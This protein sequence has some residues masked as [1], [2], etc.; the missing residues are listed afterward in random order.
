MPG[1]LPLEPRKAPRQ[2]RAKATHDALV[3]A[4]AQVL[5]R[6]GLAGF[7]TNAVATRAGVSIGSL[8]QYFPGKDALIVTL[9]RRQQA[10]QAQT[11][12]A[13][14]AEGPGPNLASTVRRLIRA[15]MAH[16]AA[17]TLLA[18]AIDHEEARLPLSAELDGNLAVAGAGLEQLLAA[19]QGE[20]GPVDLAAAGRTLP[21]LVRAAVDAWANLDPPQLAQAEEEAVRAVLGYLALR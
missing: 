15:A 18:A 21:A 2:A 4:A 17:D 3:E 20:L 1:R 9:I 5:G 8:Y 19:H 11:L 6:G 13:A 12:A 10:M 14:M 16:H 7:T